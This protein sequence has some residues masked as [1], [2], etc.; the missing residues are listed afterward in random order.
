M[1][2][3]TLQLTTNGLH[4]YCED[5]VQPFYICAEGLYALFPETKGLPELEL[6]VG[7][8]ALAASVDVSFHDH[9]HIPRVTRDGQDYYLIQSAAKWLRRSFPQA[10]KLYVLA[11]ARVQATPATEPL[12]QVTNYT[13]RREGDMMVSDSP[14]GRIEMCCSGVSSLLSLRQDD[15]PES[16][17]LRVSP[18]EKPGWIRV[19]PYG[20]GSVTLNG[21]AWN[22]FD[23]VVAWLQAASST[24]DNRMWLQVS[25]RPFEEED[26]VI[27]LTFKAVRG[28]LVAEHNGAHV[29]LCMLGVQRMMNLAS[30]QIPEEM[31]ARVSRTPRD[32]WK[33]VR[34]VSRERVTLDGVSFDAYFG[35]TDWL[36]DNGLSECWIEARVTRMSGTTEVKAP[37]PEPAPQ[38]VEPYR[39]LEFKLNNSGDTLRCATNGM[40]LCAQGVETVLGTEDIVSTLVVQISRSPVVGWRHIGRDGDGVLTA[41]GR[42]QVY[43]EVRYWLRDNDLRECWVNLVPTLVP[44]TPQPAPA[45]APAP[46]PR[47]H[48]FHVTRK[49]G[50]TDW[51][52]A[53]NAFVLC[54]DGMNA[55]NPECKLARE[56]TIQVS[57]GPIEGG[58]RVERRGP[59]LCVEG[60]T[61]YVTLGSS[62]LGKLKELGLD[63]FWLK[64]TPT[65]TVP[66]T[67]V[68]NYRRNADGADWADGEL[69]IENATANKFIPG[70]DG[71]RHLRLTLHRQAVAN[72]FRCVLEGANVVFPD[73]NHVLHIDQTVAANLDRLLI[74]RFWVTVEVDPDRAA[75]PD[76]ELTLEPHGNYWM[77]EGGHVSLCKRGLRTFVPSI[78]E[79]VRTL[80]VELF[81]TQVPD[82]FCAWRNGNG[83]VIMESSSVLAPKYNGTSVDLPTCTLGWLSDHGLQVG[84]AHR[85]WFRISGQ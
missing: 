75:R 24:P 44:R 69:E 43:D 80:K 4:Y 6:L 76:A 13:L 82:A 81:K 78:P 12:T 67:L 1:T 39:T 55:V 16:V 53:R 63:T 61:G 70:L 31:V 3:R 58:V 8:N 72:G 59:D 20:S 37:D 50:N 41:Q 2:S 18:V 77:D 54:A 65:D 85:F 36:Q 27:E 22:V 52:E 29:D 38:P 73:M 19:A 40:R 7:A 84:A 15:L 62:S 71:A 21:N 51:N 60:I 42:F 17:Y 25:A 14:Y 34:R 46:A 64:I 11:R 30:H 47:V 79:G 57:S 66:E 68:M 56:A 49:G 48:E 5:P 26:S 74:R 32:G 45:P 23:S 9:E 35:L 10:A 28:D 83:G 33:R